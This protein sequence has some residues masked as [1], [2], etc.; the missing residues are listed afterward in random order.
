MSSSEPL[1]GATS[2]WRLDLAYDGSTFRGLAEQP[3]V[4]TVA[5]ALGEALQRTLRLSAPPR[6][7]AAGRTDAGV[8]ALGQV[9]H[10]DLPEPLFADGARS[11]RL[12]TSLNHQLRGRVAVL[13][14]ARVDDAFDARFSATWRAYRYLVIDSPVPGLGSTNAWAW[15]VKGPLDVSAM[16]RAGAAALGEHDFRSFCRRPDGRDPAEPLTRR[17]LA[18]TWAR[19]EDPLTLVPSRSAPLRL[20]I[21]ARSFCHQ[22]VRC[23]VATMVAVGRGRLGEGEIAAR[24]AAPNRA[25]LPSPAPAAGLC[26]VAVGYGDDSPP[27]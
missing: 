12:V 19:V 25:G 20:D 8:H 17:V 27:R 9:V 6:L 26:L 1:T 11:D 15:S 22:M 23:L 2:R 16:N 3:G 24:L 21:T 10:C 4:E 13:A 5:R 14:M 18:L 7:V